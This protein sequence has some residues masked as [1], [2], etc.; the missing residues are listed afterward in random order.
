MTPLWPPPRY[1]KT[2]T[3]PAVYTGTRCQFLE[4][5]EKPWKTSILVFFSVFIKIHVFVRKGCHTA[6]FKTPFL[7]KH[8]FTDK[9]G[10]PL[11]QRGYRTRK[12]G[13]LTKTRI[14]DKTRV[15]GVWQTVILIL[16][17]VGVFPKMSKLTNPCLLTTVLSKMSINPCLLTTVLAKMSDLSKLLKTARIHLECL[18]NFVIFVISVFINNLVYFRFLMNI[19]VYSGFWWISVFIWFFCVW[20]WIT[21][22]W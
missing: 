9:P 16:E 18:V 4:K 22:V 7:I 10:H 3:N 5:C 14:I 15:C 21:G 12:P 20:Q 11:K 19:R 1:F 2:G 6:G 17:T 8:G 13:L